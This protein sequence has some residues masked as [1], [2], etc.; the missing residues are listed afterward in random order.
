VS[1]I[2]H[3][4]HISSVG[5]RGHSARLQEQNVVKAPGRDFDHPLFARR[6]FIYDKL[7][8]ALKFSDRKLRPVTKQNCAAVTRCALYE[9]PDPSLGLAQTNG[10]RG[11]E[12]G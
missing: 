8:G 7:D 4:L 3:R 9:A 5:N 10:K 6:K 12:S 11:T 1:F 2:A